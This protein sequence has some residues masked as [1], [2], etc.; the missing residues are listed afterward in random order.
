MCMESSSEAMVIHTDSSSAGARQGP[1]GGFGK[2]LVRT[3]GRPVMASAV[4][5]TE[6]T[7]QHTQSGGIMTY[8]YYALPAERES[9]GQE[10][11]YESQIF[12]IRNDLSFT[13]CL[14]T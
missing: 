2:K 10:S 8:P 1:R 5:V 13:E 11:S 4:L 7:R 3:G 6:G 9:Q 14:N 12:T